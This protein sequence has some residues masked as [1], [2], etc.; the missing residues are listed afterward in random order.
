MLKFRDDVGAECFKSIFQNCAAKRIQES[1]YLEAVLKFRD[2]VGAE[3]FK[4]VF[5]G[6]A[7]KRIQEKSFLD[8][9]MYCIKARDECP[10][11]VSR[12]ARLAPHLDRLSED[13][14]KSFI[15][16]S[17]GW[18]ITLSKNL[19]REIKKSSQ[20]IV[21]DEVWQGVL[22]K[23]SAH[24]KRSL[25]NVVAKAAKRKRSHGEISRSSVV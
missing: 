3:C 23:M 4:S 11:I 7:A 18:S 10:G 13:F 5:R 19:V 21:P 6:C 25:A 17:S 1:G 2:D 14:F 24:Q 15:N 8:R 12:F 22:D 20:G 9:M 16:P